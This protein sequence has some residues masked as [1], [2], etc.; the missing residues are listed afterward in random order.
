LLTL[1]RKRRPADDADAPKERQKSGK[2]DK[3]APH[4]AESDTDRFQGSW[5]LV[6]EER[7]GKLL[8]AQQI[9]KFYTFVGDELRLS[10]VGGDL[11]EPITHKMGFRLNPTKNPKEIDGR[12]NDGK[13]GIKG[14][15]LFDGDLLKV[16]IAPAS[17]DRPTIFVTNPGTNNTL[18]ILQRFVEPDKENAL[19]VTIKPQKKQ[20]RAKEPFDVDLRVVNLSKSPQSFRVMNCSWYEHWKSSNG[21]VSWQGWD[22]AENA[23]VTVKLDPGEAYEKT[24]PMLLLA[25]KPLEKVSFKVGFTPIG[26]K[27]TY[28]SNEVTVQIEADDPSDKDMAKLQ[29]TWTAVSVERDGKLISEEEVKKLDL[30][31]TIR[32]DGFMWMPLASKGPEHFPH[33]RF[34]LDTTKKPKAIDL[35]IDVP[36]SPAKKTSTVLGIYEVDGDSLKI[37]KGLPDQGRPADFKTTPRSGL[38]VITFKRAKG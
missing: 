14:I 12:E 27:Q 25:G 13:P 35:T 28:W 9:K 20:V 23:A 15:Y 29:G 3:N 17:K 38:E 22:C 5:T 18:M 32:G 10:I 34:K 7:D 16:C 24:L 31:L 26:S 2:T 11:T 36:F 37:L 1:K 8:P 19:T 4:N 30:R 21:R 6:S 33:G